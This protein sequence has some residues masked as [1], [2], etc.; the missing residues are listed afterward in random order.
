[1]IQGQLSYTRFST[2]LTDT[3]PFLSAGDEPWMSIAKFSLGWM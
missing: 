2:T 3:T 1:M